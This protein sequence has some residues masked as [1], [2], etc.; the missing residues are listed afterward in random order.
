M[1]PDLPNSERAPEVASAGLFGDPDRDWPED[2][3]QENGN[4]GHAC[5]VCKR[6]F[7]GH[8]RRHVCRD[9]NRQ[10]NERW[11]RLTPEEQAIETARAADEI[12][13]WMRSHMHSP[14]ME[15]RGARRST[16]DVER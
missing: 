7:I 4:Y 10:E 15:I 11:A 8:K 3:A 13:A 16:G 12:E 2:F 1:Q 14:N 6:G 9:C 5:V